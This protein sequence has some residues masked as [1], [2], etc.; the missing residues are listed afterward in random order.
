MAAVVSTSKSTSWV[1]SP[2]IELI[3]GLSFETISHA[4]TKAQVPFAAGDP[5]AHEVIQ[6]ETHPRVDL[7]NNP[8][9]V[10]W[11]DENCQ[12]LFVRENGNVHLTFRPRSN[13]S[14]EA[15]SGE[16]FLS[17]KHKMKAIPSVFEKVFRFPDYCEQ[18][19]ES[20]EA[21][22]YEI[23]PGLSGETGVVDLLDKDERNL[24]ILTR[25]I[26]QS[27]SLPK[28]RLD[29]LRS[30]LAIALNSDDCPTSYSFTREREEI[31]MHQALAFRVHS[32]GKLL[33][34]IGA[35]LALVKSADQPQTNL[36]QENS[37]S[38]ITKRCLFA[39]PPNKELLYKD[40]SV[41]VILNPKPYVG[42]NETNS[43][44]VL[45]VPT[46]HVEDCAG[47][48]DHEF[49]AERKAILNL[50]LEWKKHYPDHEYFIWKQ[51]GIK[52]GQTVPH[53][54]TQVLCAQVSEM[55]EYY[56]LMI[57]D[58]IHP[59]PLIFAACTDLRTSLKD[60]SWV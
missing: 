24:Y 13:V 25:G 50:R 29:D 6:I 3:T 21:F 59:P 14:F 42:W 46:H 31:N 12:V 48:R 57:Q 60:A 32:F 33:Q 55:W 34:E 47:V 26:H 1:I 36:A 16:Q 56:R 8:F 45:V 43:R 22:A 37:R 7:F 54:H 11:E 41:Q 2:N 38:H 23:F 28:D 39:N 49:L 20:T 10:V 53:L 52:A 19:I 18:L 51:Q 27:Y 5:A 40:A 4:F 15:I 58:I 30:E 9:E 35:P 17:L 44:H